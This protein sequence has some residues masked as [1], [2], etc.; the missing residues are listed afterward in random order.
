VIDN[1][2]DSS[3]SSINIGMLLG[4]RTSTLHMR[5]SQKFYIEFAPL[6]PKRSSPPCNFI[7]DYGSEIWLSHDFR[8]IGLADVAMQLN[9]HMSGVYNIT[10][11]EGRKFVLGVNASNARYIE[12]K[13]VLSPEGGFVRMC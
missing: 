5:S 3:I 2:E 4:D 6:F 12:G 13:Y 1:S 9:G 8:L 11:E 7:V 10:L